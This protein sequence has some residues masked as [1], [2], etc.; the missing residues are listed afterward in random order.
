LGWVV[1]ATYLPLYPRKR[2]L[3][4]ILREVAWVLRPVWVTAENVAFTGI[5]NA[6]QIKF[7]DM[8]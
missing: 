8:K 3:V 1:N 2:N 6:Q 4:P 7:R 5:H